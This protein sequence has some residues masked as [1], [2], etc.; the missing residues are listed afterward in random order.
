MWKE[1]PF[2]SLGRAQKVSHCVCVSLVGGWQCQ[3]QR[4]TQGFQGGPVSEV[5]TGLGNPRDICSGGPSL[6]FLPH[7]VPQNSQYTGRL[8]P[9]S[10]V[11]AEGQV[12]CPALS[13]PSTQTHIQREKNL[14]ASSWDLNVINDL[15][16]KSA[17]KPG[18]HTNDPQSLA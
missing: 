17:L 1:R 16:P 7:S 4:L 6:S 18:L 10:P 13:H 3:M 8:L 11:H 14:F 12:A 2:C 15:S 5:S 9:A